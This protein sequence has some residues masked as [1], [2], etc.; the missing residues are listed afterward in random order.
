MDVDLDL[1]AR[2]DL[3]AVTAALA[4]LYF[5]GVGIASEVVHA[6]YP[7]FGRMGA[8]RRDHCCGIVV[9]SAEA[10]DSGRVDRVF[11]QK[12]FDYR[13]TL[14]DFGRRLNSQTDLRALVDFDCGAAAA[15]ASG[16]ARGS[17]S[18]YGAKQLRRGR[19]GGGYEAPL[20]NWRFAWTGQ[21]G[22]GGPEH[23]GRAFSGLRPHRLERSHFS[24]EPTAGAAL[25][26][27]PS[28]AARACS[29]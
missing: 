12:S 5:G 24:G 29:T 15:D 26:P 3:Y 16:Y 1:Q 7:A 13:E 22:N 10:D 27:T 25:C 2:R 8:D 23:A 4:G 18:G 19:R 9:R 14:I 17:V 20:S 21:P 28:S 6:H 11:D